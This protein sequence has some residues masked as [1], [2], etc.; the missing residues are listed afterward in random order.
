MEKYIVLQDFN[1]NN[2]K[3]LSK[4][5][6]SYI[7]ICLTDVNSNGRCYQFYKIFDNN[8]KLITSMYTID[9]YFLKYSEYR[10]EK[11]NKIFQ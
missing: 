9:D 3:K 4:N 11:I 1:V 7:E 2:I 6:I 8:K 5:D 10:K